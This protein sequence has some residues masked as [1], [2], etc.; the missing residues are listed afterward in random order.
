[1]AHSGSNRESVDVAETLCHKRDLQVPPSHRSCF[2]S[3]VSLTQ[4]ISPFMAGNTFCIF[5]A[6]V[7][8]Y[9][10]AAVSQIYHYILS[11][12]SEAGPMPRRLCFWTRSV[13]KGSMLKWRQGVRGLQGAGKTFQSHSN[14]MK[15]L[16]FW[17]R[18]N[19]LNCLCPTVRLCYG[20]FERTHEVTRAPC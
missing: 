3:A 4:I 6:E 15:T 1:M 11:L 10:L 14:K 13:V 7:L 20:V 12:R 5:R 18:E 17:Q 16:F 9:Q 8:P 2:W 19:P